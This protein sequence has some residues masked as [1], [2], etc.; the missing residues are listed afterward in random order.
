MGSSELSE[1]TRRLRQWLDE[2]P[3]TA[4]ASTVCSA[5]AAS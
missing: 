1:V 4:P 2:D 5:P 3:G